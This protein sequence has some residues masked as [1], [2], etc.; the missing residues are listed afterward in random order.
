MKDSFPEK[1]T[2]NGRWQTDLKIP[3]D[4]F[5]IQ[6]LWFVVFTLVRDGHPIHNF[7]SSSYRDAQC[8]RL[9]KGVSFLL[10]F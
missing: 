9:F 6:F 10:F 1:P 2:S 7:Y 3:E 4:H 8:S 5:P